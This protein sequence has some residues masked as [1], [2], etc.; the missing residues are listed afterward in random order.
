MK[1]KQEILEIIDNPVAR[2]RIALDLH[3]GEQA[4]AFQ[5]KANRDNGRMTRMD[6]LMA[7]AKETGKSIDEILERETISA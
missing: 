7:I 1:V 3:I 5:V 6:F 4:V 2:T